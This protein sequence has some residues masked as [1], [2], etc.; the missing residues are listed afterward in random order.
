MLG[1]RK[2]RLFIPTVASEIKHVLCEYKSS[3]RLSG[4]ALKIKHQMMKHQGRNRG[5]GGKKRRELQKNIFPRCV[6]E[7]TQP[8]T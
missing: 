5:S 8:V 6:L 3:P 2:E 1:K 7:S 4:E